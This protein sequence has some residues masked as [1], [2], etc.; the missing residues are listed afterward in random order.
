VL[1]S[2]NTQ[3]T[4]TSAEDAPMPKTR[5]PADS[6]RPRVAVHARDPLAGAGL[7]ALLR[8]QPNLEL[9]IPAQRAAHD[10][11]VLVLVSDES[12][13]DLVSTLRTLAAAHPDS[14]AVL[15]VD[16]PRNLDLF[17]AVDH[18]VVGVLSRTQATGQRLLDAIGTVCRGGAYLP[19]ASQARLVEQVRYVQRE[20]LRPQGLH[21]HGL[22]NRELDV[23]RLVADGLGLREI[24]TKLA[25]S[26][27]TVKNIVHAATTRLGM[28]NRIEVVAYAAR[29][30]AI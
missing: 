4:T 18:G 27:R 1:E 25:Y 6:S 23:I 14:R 19:P 28:R 7:A 10:V 26:E 8:D 2:E 16:D 20:L 13:A 29:L 30:G 9:V 21:A 3:L 24:G 5:D 11:D 12:P 15:I 17:H 22:T